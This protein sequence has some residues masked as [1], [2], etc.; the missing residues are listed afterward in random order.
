MTGRPTFSLLA[1]ITSRPGEVVRRRAVIA[2]AWPN[3]A[4]VSENTLDSYATRI[5]RKLE[6]IG[7]PLQLRNVRGVG[8][9]LR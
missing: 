6:Q 2:A 9:Q 5:R 7:S 8:Y 3:G 1:A 4:L